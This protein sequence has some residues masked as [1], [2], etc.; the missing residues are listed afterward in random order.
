MVMWIKHTN[1]SIAQGRNELQ[2][3]LELPNGISILLKSNAELYSTTMPALGEGYRAVSVGV[4]TTFLVRNKLD[5]TG[6]ALRLQ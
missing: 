4:A 1:K 2:A 6:N 5:Y 3:S